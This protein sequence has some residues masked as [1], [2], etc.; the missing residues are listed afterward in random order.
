MNID[1]H[2]E[3]VFP[4]TSRDRSLWCRGSVAAFEVPNTSTRQ[5]MLN[6]WIESTQAR[7][8]GNKYTGCWSN[9]RT[10]EDSCHRAGTRRYALYTRSKVDIFYELV[11]T[12]TMRNMDK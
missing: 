10:R 8:E 1:A 2:R 7:S 4:K 6:T 5:R 12:T 11:A 9:F 3:G